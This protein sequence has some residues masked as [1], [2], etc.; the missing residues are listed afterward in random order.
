MR[1]RS[2]SKQ[3]EQRKK[4]AA[5]TGVGH[6]GV[7]VQAY[8]KTA[9]DEGG[10]LSETS[11]NEMHGKVRRGGAA[12]DTLGEVLPPFVATHIDEHQTLTRAVHQ[13]DDR[14]G[15]RTSASYEGH[16]V[17]STR[18]AGTHGD[19]AVDK[20]ISQPLSPQPYGEATYHR[21]HASP[22]NLVGTP[23][24]SAHTVWAP[25]WANIA[26]D[27][28]MERRAQHSAKKGHEVY[29]FRVDTA[30]HST[31]G[32]VKKHKDSKEFKAFAATYKRR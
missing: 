5:M 15:P 31:V 17:T 19:E 13:V 14:V 9:M 12:G 27:G 3:E 10:S 1:L 25:G 6:F 28:Y 21:T 32:Y 18:V 22:F 16:Q 23:S 24:N 20:T 8:V 26:V 7:D 4:V 29:H 2:T 11:R 30:T